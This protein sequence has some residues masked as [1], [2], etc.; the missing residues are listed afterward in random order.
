MARQTLSLQT[1]NAVYSL[2]GKDLTLTAADATNKEEAVIS[3]RIFLVAFNSGVSSRT[4]TVNSVAINNRTG[5][6]TAHSI[7]AGGITLLGPFPTT[8]YAQTGGKLY[9]EA[10]HA[11]I[12]WAVVKLP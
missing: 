3:D 2:T 11:D 6:V 9:F 7:A 1:F 12:K 10:S 4:V 8:G 5:D